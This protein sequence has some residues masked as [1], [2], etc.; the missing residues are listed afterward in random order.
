M[1][2]ILGIFIVA[3]V[4]VAAYMLR[5]RIDSNAASMAVGVLF[6]LLSS[7][8]MFA[9]VA[10]EQ[11]KTQQVEHHHTHDVAVR[12]IPSNIQKAMAHYGADDAVRINGQW[13]LLDGDR[14]VSSQRLLAG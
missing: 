11:R 13:L 5:Q 8:P 9:M 1:K 6:G 3:F 14:V 10:A 7:L 12:F 4:G 2:T